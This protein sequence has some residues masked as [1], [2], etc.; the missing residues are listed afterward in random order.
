MSRAG[1]RLRRR[2]IVA[3]SLAGVLSLGAAAAQEPPHEA[4][5]A[6]AAPPPNLA[7][8][9]SEEAPRLRIGGFAQTD[10]VVTRQASLDEVDAS[11]GA[12]LN[13]ERFLLRRAR[14]RLDGAHRF[15][16]GRIEIDL[17]SVQG[18][19]A[20]P[21]EVSLA[22]GWSA[23]GRVRWLGVGRDSDPLNEAPSADEG[24]ETRPLSVL[25]SAGLVRIPFG[26]DASEQP[27]VRPFLERTRMVRALFPGQRDLG[28]GFD[29]E[30]QVFRLSLALMNGAPIGE[31]SG[32]AVDF[33][34]SKDVVGRIGVDVPLGNV[35]IEAGL[36]ATT[37]QGLHPGTAE[38]KD[39]LNWQ[40][41]NED[42]LVELSELSVIP[43]APAT[44]SR[45]F[46]HYALGADA[47]LSVRWP[48][49]GELSLRGELIRAQ[50]LDRGLEPAD[51]VAMGRDLRELGWAV[52][53]SQELT[54]YAQ[55]AARYESYDP[56]ADAREV[57]GVEIVPRSSRYGTLSVAAAA[58]IAPLRFLAQFDHET[59][60]LGRGPNGEPVTLANDGFTLRAE[61]TLR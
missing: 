48:V 18:L 2:V 6:E 54:A 52:A 47:R 1:S 58:R 22:A 14:L 53:V 7:G 26:F 41:G 4:V 40:D 55:L 61:I 16:L 24:A 32:A 27:T 36:S 15:A 9:V 46:D 23:S 34:S 56:D 5:A 21:F 38:T 31:V 33:T 29:A 49:L 10:W 8:P 3:C 43:G 51:P 13:D 44:A 19:E 30:Y 45:T 59:N 57:R 50:N 42:G 28:I 37:G 39:T 35:Q 12:S 11:T 17:S 25:A 60:S 20:R